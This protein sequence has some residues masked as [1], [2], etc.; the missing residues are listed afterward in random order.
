MQ[1]FRLFF[2]EWAG[3]AQLVEHLICNQ[4]VGGSNPFASSSSRETFSPT[5][6]VF[7][8][9]GPQRFKRL[10]SAFLWNRMAAVFAATYSVIRW[11]GTLKFN[12]V[13]RSTLAWCGVLENELGSLEMM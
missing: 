1:T 2:A 6:S 11:S 8:L 9:R 12:T 10:L 7:A 5:N 4:A 3:V 13:S